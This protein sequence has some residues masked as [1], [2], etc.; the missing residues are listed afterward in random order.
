MGA[1]IP[2]LELGRAFALLTNAHYR[3]AALLRSGNAAEAD[4]LFEVI[5]D[6]VSRFP[7]EDDDDESDNENAT[8]FGEMFGSNLRKRSQVL[9]LQGDFGGATKRLEALDRLPGVRTL[10][11]ANAMADLGLIAGGSRS[12]AAILPVS[13]DPEQRR[14]IAMAL[15]KGRARFQEAIERFG[16]EAANA[17]FCLGILGLISESADPLGTADHWRHALAG[18]LRRQFAYESS[19][20]I[21]WARFALGISLLESLE[22]S[23]YQHADESIAQ[24]LQAPTRFPIWL[25]DRALR[26]ASAFDDRSL[27]EKTASALL[28]SRAEEALPM[29]L[30]NGAADRNSNLRGEVLRMLDEAVFPILARWERLTRLLPGALNDLSDQGEQIL[31]RLEGIA[32]ECAEFRPNFITL[33]SNSRFYSPAWE[34]WDAETALVR[35][36]LSGGQFDSAKELLLRRFYR[37]LEAGKDYERVEAMNILDDVRGFP[38]S[39]SSEIDKLAASWPEAIEGESDHTPWVTELKEGGKLRALYV[40]GN[41]TQQQYVGDLRKLITEEFPGVELEFEMPG[42]SSNWIVDAERVK[43]KLSKFDVLVLN[44]L[45]RTQFGRH[46]R[47]ACG[48]HCPWIGCSGKGKESLRRSIRQGVLFAAAKRN[49]NIKRSA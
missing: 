10:D 21:D 12:I 40:G 27:L 33:L 22:P 43:G 34:P 11:M 14:T 4:M 6:S 7:T 29:L 41:E 44:N 31:D 20:M 37:L 30:E 3:G 49:G 15:E 46:V 1:Q 24:A 48:A 23:E 32:V 45:V 13:N 2:K 35:M 47:K 16:G 8:A 18:T 39:D 9:Q 5:E 38:G 28:A 25:W 19:G 42:W 26:A 17:H 36:F